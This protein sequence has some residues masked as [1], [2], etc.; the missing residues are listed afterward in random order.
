MTWHI[1]LLL[2]QPSTLLQLAVVGE[3]RRVHAGL[4]ASLYFGSLDPLLFQ[5]F[6]SLSRLGRKALRGYRRS[7]R[8]D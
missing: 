2:Q 8:R 7:R 3:L 1:V 4:R 5:R 6:L